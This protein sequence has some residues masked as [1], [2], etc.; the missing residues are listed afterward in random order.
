[1][2]RA[3]LITLT[4]LCLFGC[5][6]ADT[7][8]HIVNVDATSW[9]E[10]KDPSAYVPYRM[11]DGDERTS[12]QFSTRTTALGTEYV[13][14]YFDGSYDIS[15]LWIK[16]GF[17]KYT[18]GHDQYVRNSRV[19]KIRIDFQYSGDSY[20]SDAQTITLPDDSKRT[21]WARISLGDKHDVESVRF[22]IQDIYRGTKYPND[23]CIS[24]VRFMNGDSAPSPYAGQLYGLATQKLA[25]RDGPGTNYQGKGTYEVAGQ[26]IHVLSRAWDSRNRIWWVKCEIPY[27]NSIRVLWTGYKRF[28][29]STLP[30]ESIPVEGEPVSYHPAV[31]AAPAPVQPV[32]GDWSSIYRDFVM[33]GKYLTSGQAYYRYEGSESAFGLYDMDRDGIPE[34]IATNGDDSMAGKSEY[35]YTIR[36]GRL[37]YAGEAGYRECRMYYYPA[38]SYSGLFCSDGNM[39]YY[40]T[41]YYSLTGGRV[42]SEEVMESQYYAD[43]DPYTWLDEPIV[44]Q[45][46]PDQD[47]FELASEGGIAQ[48]E[49]RQYT[50]AD[51]RAMGGWE[52]FVQT[53]QAD[54]KDAPSW[55]AL[56]RNFIT[57]GEYRDN[58]YNPEPEYDELLHDRDASWDMFALHDM[59]GDGIPE[60]IAQTIYG[61]EQAEV[62]ACEGNRVMRLGMMGGDN[63]F[64]DIFYY[65]EYPGLFTAM[66]GP[67][68]DVDHYTVVKGLLERQSVG[69]TVVNDDGDDTIGLRMD[70]SD[71][72]LYSLLYN[73]LVGT[74]GTSRSLKWTLPN[75]LQTEDQWTAFF[76]SAS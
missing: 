61:I 24:E 6:A 12:F 52:A 69:M 38:S 45:R 64:Q 33:N 76:N 21:D 63:F 26:Y 14:F 70:I 66:G 44:R 28:D 56:Y 73:T 46:T 27:R 18:D 75:T 74:G 59:D 3:V 40:S 10:G 13:Y 41:M 9:I 48:Y 58:L 47:L 39:G 49:V 54:I 20:Y 32:A 65:P 37:A 8:A 42:K 23:V 29:S 16:N 30:L 19:K 31:T 35:I 68:M 60:L 34:L 57:S 36:S 50:A 53:Q 71:S 7:E 67:A 62:F 4:I 25:T 15:T 11:I 22:L 17:W 51:I 1:M 5:A 2:K 43:D 72:S 55:K